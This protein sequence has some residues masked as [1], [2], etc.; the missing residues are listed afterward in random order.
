M[1]KD[2]NIQMSDIQMMLG[3]LASMIVHGETFPDGLSKAE[4]RSHAR[5]ML[6]GAFERGSD[7]I[8]LLEF[9]R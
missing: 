3:T 6:V 9:K 5:N 1:L 2:A 4:L 7:S 8:S